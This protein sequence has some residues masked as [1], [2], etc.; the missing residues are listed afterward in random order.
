MR[1]RLVDI[2]YEGHLKVI[3]KLKVGQKITTKDGKEIPMS[4]DYFKADGK[5]EAL[6]HKT[7]GEKPQRIKVI[8][9]SN[10]IEQVCNLRYEFRK[11]AK[12][13]A[14]GDGKTFDVWDGKKYVEKTIE[15]EKLEKELGEAQKVLTI[16]FLIPELKGIYGLWQLSTRG[17]NSIGPIVATFDKILEMAGTIINI[18]FELIVEKVV[19]QKPDSKASFPII[20]LIPNL[21][22]EALEIVGAAI[23]QGKEFRGLITEEKVGRFIEEEPELLE[24]QGR[25]IEAEEESEVE[26]NEADNSL[27]EKPDSPRL[28]EIE[29]KLRACQNWDEYRAVYA[30]V[31]TMDLTE[32]EKIKADIIRK[33]VYDG[34]KKVKV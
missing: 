13:Y 16:R 32:D 30:T 33:E 28:K 4:L 27:F 6:F 9:V 3:G 23:E 21:S 14:R 19:S 34:L 29:T 15:M 1:G 24:Y 5:F 18:P 31:K 26:E 20:S 25:E 17:E 2:Q 7:F 22:N 10:E 8:F 12:L 11:G